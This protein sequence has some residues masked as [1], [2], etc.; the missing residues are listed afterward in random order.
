[1]YRLIQL[2][3]ECE[4]HELGNSPFSHNRLGI[5]VEQGRQ[6]ILSGCADSPHTC[7]ESKPVLYQKLGINCGL[8]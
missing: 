7:S 6:K 4:S 8:S 5:K 2:Y 1:M 3:G